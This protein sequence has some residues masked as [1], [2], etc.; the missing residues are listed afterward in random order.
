M[1][2][3]IICYKHYVFG[4]ISE[5]RF[6]PLHQPLLGG[7]ESGPGYCD[8]DQNTLGLVHNSSEDASSGGGLPSSRGERA[9]SGGLP[10]SSGTPSKGNSAAPDVV[11]SPESTTSL[12]LAN[13]ASCKSWLPALPQSQMCTAPPLE[14]GPQGVGFIDG[15]GIFRYRRRRAYNADHYHEQQTRSPRLR[16]TDTSMDASPAIASNLKALVPDVTPAPAASPRVSA[17]L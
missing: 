9:R 3:S 8:I 5:T 6:P 17:A 7:H 13:T 15:Q 10:S 2:Y 16:R 1:N 11:P 12:R 14:H 4:I